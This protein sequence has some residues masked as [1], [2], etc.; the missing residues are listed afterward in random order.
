MV[1]WVLSGVIDVFRLSGREV[2]DGSKS[3]IVDDGLGL[4]VGGGCGESEWRSGS[5][6][7]R[8]CH[9]RLAIKPHAL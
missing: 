7:A 5:S 3:V 6:G 1:A 8:H 9:S 4:G 2:I